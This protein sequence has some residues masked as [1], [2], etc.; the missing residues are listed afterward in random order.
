[1]AA[2]KA[3]AHRSGPDRR[4]ALV[5]AAF[6]CIADRGFEGLRLRQVAGDAGI[7][8]STL[9]HYFSTK[10]ELIAG[11]VEYATRQFWPT[12]PA[13]G[14]P[15]ER[16]HQHL[17]NLARMI[18]ERPSLFVVLRE[19]ELRASHDPVVRSVMDHH[20]EG[21]R[22]ALTA[23]LKPGA[24]DGTWAEDA[25]D[26]SVGVELIMAT[27]RGV[28][29]T[30]SRAGDVLRQLGRLLTGTTSEPADAAASEGG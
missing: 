11:V 14:S 15:A 16:L 6:D 27:V 10:E 9:H 2:E 7:D 3:T 21:W 25:L 30:P 29:L 5:R 20:D 18:A 24:A 26:L 22:G 17:E 1:M 28:N 19:L 8:H 4:Q 13:E 12:V 23:V